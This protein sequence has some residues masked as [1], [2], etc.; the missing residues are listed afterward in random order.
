[1]K[2]ALLVLSLLVLSLLA[3]C[4]GCPK[5][6]RDGAPLMVATVD[7]APISRLAFAAELSRSGVA[8]LADEE[9]R[10]SLAEQVLERM[11]RQELLFKAA[12]DEGVIVDAHDVERELRKS[13]A[14]YPP[15]LFRRV[16]HAEQLS[17]EQYQDRLHK[18]A[19]VDRFLRLRFSKLPEPSAEAVLASYEETL[20]GAPRPARVR[21]RQ[22]LVKT[23]EEAL[24]LLEE[25]AKKRLSFEEA[26]RRFSESPEKE[27]GGDLG[28]F[29]QGAMPPVFEVCFSLEPGKVSEVVPSEFGFHLFLLLE[30]REGAPETFEEAR[31]RVSAELLRQRQEVAYAALVEELRA[32]AKVSIS[33]EGFALALAQLP[34]GPFEEE[35]GPE[36]APSPSVPPEEAGGVLKSSP[37]AKPLP[38]HR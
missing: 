4:V 8:R 14:G 35:R 2:A 1:M 32:K 27:E 3:L 29:A 15:G 9:E 20:A 23:E 36:A 33:E 30:K 26:A 21:V 38:E 19:T 34:F 25:I 17:Y 7:E 13:A 16:L 6:P 18:K 37:K 28:W 10:A 24:H 22:I 31:P 5:D 12:A 11:I